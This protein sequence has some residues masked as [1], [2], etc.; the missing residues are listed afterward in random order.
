[1]RSG[2]IRRNGTPSSDRA[3]F[4][5]WF[6]RHGAELTVLGLID[7]PVYLTEPYLITRDFSYY[8]GPALQGSG[9]P[10]VITNEG[11]PEGVH[12]FFLRGHN[13][14]LSPDR[15]ATTYGLPVD[16]VRGGAKTMY[17]EYRKT[18]KDHY[19]RPAECPSRLIGANAER[20]CGGAGLYPR[21]A[22]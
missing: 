18:L 8:T 21:R 7:D 20:V 13:P 22:L 6:L 16:A 2:I 4:T 19:K 15:T 9:A 14:F 3:T 12:S 5:M 1:M 17:P 11:V 10:C